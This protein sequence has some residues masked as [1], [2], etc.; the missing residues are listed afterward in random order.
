MGL[1]VGVDIG[2]TKVLA[3]VVNEDGLVL[4]QTKT[5]TPTTDPDAIAD[6]IAT[7]VD[8][9]RTRHTIEAVGIGAAGFID[10]ARSKVMFAANLVWRDE[11]LRERVSR[12]V[13]VPVIVENDANCHAW[14]E[15]RFG[16]GRGR[17]DLV[18]AIIGTGIGGGIVLNGELYR[19]GFGA[20]AEF[21]HYR[22]VPEGRLCGCGN[23]GCWEQYASGSALVRAAREVAET[24]PASVSSLLDAVGGDIDGITGPLVTEAARQGDVGALESFSIVGRWLGQGLA[25]LAEILDPSCLL[26]GG[27]VSDAG[28]LLLAPA[29]VAFAESFS[30]GANRPHPTL[31]GAELGSAAGLVGAADLARRP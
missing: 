9:F 25:D 28:E 17:S 23:R 3:G 2:G 10:A 31:V 6:I 1:T 5:A 7:L 26:I 27:G 16:A 4:E 19:G 15:A 11:P 13:D 20:A 30:G 21:G 14:A 12:V 22:V 29:R 8:G 24:A 18:C